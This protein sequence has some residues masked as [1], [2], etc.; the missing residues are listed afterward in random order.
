M[1]S[2]L[3]ILMG[4]YATRSRSLRLLAHHDSAEAY[5]NQLAGIRVQKVDRFGSRYVEIKTVLKLV[6]HAGKTVWVDAQIYRAGAAVAPQSEFE[7]WCV[8]SSQTLGVSL[9][10]LVESHRVV[11]DDVALVIPLAAFPCTSGHYQVIIQVRDSSGETLLVGAHSISARLLQTQTE[12]MGTISAG[13]IPS[14]Q[15][16]EMWDTNPGSGDA[17]LYF[18]VDK[19]ADVS[20]PI[21]TSSWRISGHEGERVS[22]RWRWVTPCGYALSR[23]QQLPFFIEGAL[24]QLREVVITPDKVTDKGALLEARICSEEG[25][26]LCGGY[27]L[28][29]GQ[30]GDRVKFF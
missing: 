29:T 30:K 3:R 25:R 22:V 16:S 7:Q 11:I 28:F 18:G 26:T 17:L 27:L 21:V 9:P 24:T 14:P 15:R 12:E 5:R 2:R 4:W 1:L 6:G 10:V 23:E 8:E 20:V 19:T 13:C